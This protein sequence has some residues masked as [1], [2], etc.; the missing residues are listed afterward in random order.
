MFCLVATLY[1]FGDYIELCFLLNFK[2]F[3]PIF[4]LTM[5]VLSTSASEKWENSNLSPLHKS[6]PKQVNILLDIR[7]NKNM[8]YPKELMYFYCELFFVFLIW[9][10]NVLDVLLTTNELL[11]FFRTPS[12][13][14]YWFYGIYCKLKSRNIYIYWKS[15]R[16]I[17]MK[18]SIISVLLCIHSDKKFWK[19]ALK[20]FLTL[21][22]SCSFNCSLKYLCFPR[23]TVR[24]DQCSFCV[25]HIVAV[26]IRAR[27]TVDLN[28]K[29]PIGSKHNIREV[30]KWI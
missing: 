1:H 7:C 30:K 9:H 20:F 4:R 28:R 27:R 2:F 11:D 23:V 13:I 17:G 3:L 12:F 26:K 25:P 15:N 6:F 16:S 8:I 14:I 10:Q 29:E 21:L 5:L 24:A 18:N 22:T 19:N